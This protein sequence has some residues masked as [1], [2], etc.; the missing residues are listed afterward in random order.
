MKSNVEDTNDDAALSKLSAVKL[1]YYKDDYLSHFVRN[2]SIR[3]SPLIN[4]G[5]FARIEAR[6]TLVAKFL[7]VTKNKAQIL[8]LG[9]GSDTLYFRLKADGNA[10]TKFVEVDLESVILR[11]M[12]VISSTPQLSVLIGESTLSQ[13]PLLMLKGAD[14]SLACLDLQEPSRFD[15]VFLESCGLDPTLPTLVLSECVLVYVEPS[16]SATV[17]E[18]VS[19]TFSESAFFVYE[20]ILPNDAFGQIIART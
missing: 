7:S 6:D 4:R 1:G 14:Y 16:V 8:S 17:I 15:A 12:K 13:Q 2:T 11:K 20:Q 18:W 9:A 19:R 5:Y 10:P 3:R